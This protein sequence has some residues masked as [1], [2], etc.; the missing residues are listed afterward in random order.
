VQ[1]HEEK[2]AR[3]FT[4]SGAIAAA[5]YNVNRKRSAHTL[6][7]ADIFP[8]LKRHRGLPRAA[9][10]AELHMMF[11]GIAANFRKNGKEMTDDGRRTTEPSSVSGPRSS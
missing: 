2:I 1:C 4:R 10:V 3:D 7:P 11:Q 9:T 8:T 6:G 5:V